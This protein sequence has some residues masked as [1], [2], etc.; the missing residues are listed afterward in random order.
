M[1]FY[2]RSDTHFL[3]FVYDNLQNELLE[4]SGGRSDTLQ[5]VWSKSAT[6]A[7]NLYQKET[8]NQESAWALA[9]K[10]NKGLYGKQQAIFEAVYMWR[11]RVAREEDESPR[12]VTFGTAPERLADTACL[13]MC[14]PIIS[15]LRWRKRHPQM[16]LDSCRVCSPHHHCLGEER[17]NCCKS[18]RKQSLRRPQ[19]RPRKLRSGRLRRHL[20]L[21]TS[22]LGRLRMSLCLPETMT[23]HQVGTRSLACSCVRLAD[24]V[25]S[26]ASRTV[27]SGPL[28]PLRGSCT[29]GTNQYLARRCKVRTSRRLYAVLK[30]NVTDLL[31]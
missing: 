23:S 10:W 2:A 24:I 26:F 13:D 28:R 30:C 20:E 17:M 8:V 21:W 11:D 3:L 7:L 27:D 19:R 6:T 18:S 14:F 31:G 16:S 29:L 25:S 4:R 22:T 12:Y 15:S 9:R 5:T 1:L